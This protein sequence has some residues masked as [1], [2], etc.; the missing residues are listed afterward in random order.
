MSPEI[1]ELIK[2]L[3]VPDPR[4]F[5]SMSKNVTALVRAVPLLI[6]EIRRLEDETRGL[7]HNVEYFKYLATTEEDEYVDY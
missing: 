7:R 3:K 4:S 5:V 1:E 6:A 2:N